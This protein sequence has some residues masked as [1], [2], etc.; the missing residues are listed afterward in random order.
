MPR[1]RPSDIGDIHNTYIIDENS[2]YVG[3]H[4]EHGE[5]YV[6]ANGVFD[7]ASRHKLLSFLLEWEGLPPDVPPVVTATYTSQELPTYTGQSCYVIA[8][9]TDRRG[10]EEV[11]ILFPDGLTWWTQPDSI[12]DIHGDYDRMIDL[13]GARYA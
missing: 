2:A 9:F 3:V 13:N 12:T 8:K 10:D 5:L 11:R 7:R 6:T 4:N 1:V